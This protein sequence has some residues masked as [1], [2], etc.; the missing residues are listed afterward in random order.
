VVVSHSSWQHALFAPVVR[1]AGL[2]LVFWAHDAMIHRSWLDIWASFTPPDLLVANSHFTRE[3]ARKVFAPVRSEVVYLP[4]PP[5]SFPAGARAAL[6]QEFETP[7][8][9]VVIVLACQLDRW[10]GHGL[11]LEAL[12]L[13]RD[14]PDWACWIAGGAQRPGEARYFSELSARVRRSGLVGRVEFVGQ[15]ADVPALLSA[16]DIHCQPDTGG[17]PFG[18]TFLEA[19]HAG[20]PVVTTRLGEAEEILDASCGVLVPPQ[21]EALAEALAALI[22]NPSR[23]AMLGKAG[24]ARALALCEPARQIAKINELLADVA[25]SFKKGAHA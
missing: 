19:L 9:T 10:K 23:R 17:E 24:P 8:D 21:P 2:P 1:K 20:L 22:R 5:P 13:L 16:G 11:L 18:L 6:R 14:L 15:R 3:S 4:V 25:R 7:D 12:L